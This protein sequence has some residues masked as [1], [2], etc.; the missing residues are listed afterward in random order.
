MNDCFETFIYCKNC[1]YFD[2]CN[3]K[4]NRDGCYLG[5]ENDEEI[6]SNTP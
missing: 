3:S 6:E 5:D 4:E 1:I 2:E